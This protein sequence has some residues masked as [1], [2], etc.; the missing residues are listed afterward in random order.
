MSNVFLRRWC[1]AFLLLAC[2]RFSNNDAT[3][4]HRL[5]ILPKTS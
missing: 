5:D 1:S 2:D 3:L 4:G